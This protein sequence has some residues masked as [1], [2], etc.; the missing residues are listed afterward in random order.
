MP[1][2]SDQGPTTAL[3]R[4]DPRRTTRAGLIPSRD[5][6][7]FLAVT[8]NWEPRTEN[9]FSYRLALRLRHAIFVS[10]RLL[11]A[12]RPQYLFHA[13]VF[14]ITLELAALGARRFH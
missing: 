9:W 7:P 4:F 2:A 5:E 13:D 8:E 12:A 3:T 1:M 11:L 6:C 14:R 10:R